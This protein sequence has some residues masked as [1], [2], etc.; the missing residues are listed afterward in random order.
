MSGQPRRALFKGTRD[1]PTRVDGA[2]V[3]AWST[4]SFLLYLVMCWGLPGIYSPGKRLGS[5]S[6]KWPPPFS[7]A[8]L[9]EGPACLGHFLR[10]RLPCV[11]RRDTG[12]L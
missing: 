6:S 11:P 4:D 2:V 7:S 9:L 10:E 12:R 8:E 3:S 1:G 5:R